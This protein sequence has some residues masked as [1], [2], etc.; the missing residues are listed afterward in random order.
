MNAYI[1]RAREQAQ[2]L[3]EGSPEQ[4]AA[5]RDYERLL[6]LRE[7]GTEAA[8]AQIKAEAQEDIARKAYL[9]ARA[10]LGGLTFGVSDVLLKE[11]EERTGER[12]TA[13]STDE[14]ISSALA[15]FVGSVVSQQGLMRGL[16]GLAKARKMGAFGQFALQRMGGN[17]LAQGARQLSAMAAGDKDAKMAARDFLLNYGSAMVA[18]LPENAMKPGMANAVAQVLTDFTVDVLVDKYRGR[19]E[20]QSFVHWLLAEELPNLAMSVAAAGEDLRNPRQLRRQQAAIKRAF[21]R[22]LKRADRVGDIGRIGQEVQ[23][24][25]AIQRVE[26]EVRPEEGGEDIRR[27]GPLEEVAVPAGEKVE[28]RVAAQQDPF[29]AFSMAAELPGKTKTVVVEPDLSTTKGRL[30]AAADETGVEYNPRTTNQAIRDRVAKVR[31]DRAKS[32]ELAPDEPTMS[33]AR[34]RLERATRFLSTEGGFRSIGAEETGFQVKTYASKKQVAGQRALDAVKELNAE[35]GDNPVRAAHAFFQAS[36]PKHVDRVGL[37]PEDA[38]S[39]KRTGEAL[40]KFMGDYYELL[41]ARDVLKA[42]WPD[43]HI[44]RINDQIKGWQ[45]TKQRIL[46]GK[47]KRTTQVQV[48]DGIE[49]VPAD[50]PITDAIKQR[51]LSS[52]DA[53]IDEAT[54][55][56]NRLESMRY[57]HFPARVWLGDKADTDPEGFRTILSGNFKGIKDRKTIDPFDLTQI[58]DKDGNAVLDMSKVDVRDAVA[59]YVR[60]VETQLA[61]ADIRDAAIKDGLVLTEKTAPSDWVTLRSDEFPAFAGRKVHPV[62]ALLLKQ[63]FNAEGYGGGKMDVYDKVAAATKMAQFANPIIM[64]MYDTLQGFALTQGVGIRNFPQAVKHV[65][66]HTPEYYEAAS[67]GLFSKPY[68]D[69]WQKFQEGLERTKAGGG[70]KG[71]VEAEA[72]KFVAS[73]GVGKNLAL[74]PV[75]ALKD[76]Y[77][78]SWATAWAGDEA[79]RM[80]SYLEMRKRGFDPR[81]AAQLAAEAHAD[82]AGVPARTRRAANRVLF[83]PTFQISMMKWFGKMMTG[84]AKTPKH[85]VDVLAGKGVSPEARRDMQNAA[86]MLTAVGAL[87]AGDYALTSLLGWERE[88]FGRKYKK[89]A[90]D[91]NGEEKEVVVTFSNPLNVPL[92]Y[93]H[94]FVRT[95]EGMTK[96]EQI[97]RYGQFHLHPMWRIGGSVLT[98]QRPNGDPITNPWAGPVDNA[99]ETTRFMAGQVIAMMR[100]LV[101]EPDYTKSEAFKLLNQNDG[102]ALDQMFKYYA[103]AYIRE[104]ED[105]RYKYRVQGLVRRFTEHLRKRPPK[106][107]A[108][109]DALYERLDKDLAR[110]QESASKTAIQRSV[111]QTRGKQRLAG[112]IAVQ[113]LD[114]EG[115]FGEEEYED[116]KRI[117]GLVSPPS[118]PGAPNQ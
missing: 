77:R 100:N 21:S 37:S 14:Q 61:Q 19:F 7:T 57:M 75:R 5:Q 69:P 45:A 53:N 68:A 32:G 93:Y 92:K 58:V 2:T 60:Y 76:L 17:A 110:I 59:T 10:A 33:T 74:A 26:A 97:G 78:A 102:K 15:G 88:E 20:D 64:P 87:T 72:K 31:A 42:P 40:S 83:T 50:V 34:Q 8:M 12:I 81:E 114:R 9:P 101:D 94:Q 44:N 71:L 18:M 96:P 56:I 118:M 29:E 73:N 113:I 23:D 25:E 4:A 49:K 106:T 62:A 84:T 11:I 1:G 16:G 95:R 39:V 63:Q 41:E 66:K 47:I 48:A 99:V 111:A 108:E 55:D 105:V 115:A 82:Y 70:L 89:I 90:T 13:E 54:R 24:A 67:N 112:N 116:F 117:K 35:V 65:A 103:F 107:A 79:I 104:P 46:D 51:M 98:N 3:P 86:S 6:N 80:A 85:V 27:E 22:N 109:M 38:A 36:H 28:A 91:E 52:L 43:S 30:R